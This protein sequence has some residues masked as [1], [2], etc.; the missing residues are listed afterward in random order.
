MNLYKILKSK[1]FLY[2][3]V[4]QN[5]FVSKITYELYLKCSL[6]KYNKSTMIG[7]RL[8]HDNKKF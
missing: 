8:V 4:Q 3:L 7:H 1:Y 2:H 6:N 5:K